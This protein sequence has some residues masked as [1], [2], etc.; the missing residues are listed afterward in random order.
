MLSKEAQEAIDYLK[1]NMK[2]HVQVSKAGGWGDPDKIRVE[3]Q[4]CLGDELIHE[5]SDYTY[6]SD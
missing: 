4:V 5:D 3:L 6:L 2:V 1:E